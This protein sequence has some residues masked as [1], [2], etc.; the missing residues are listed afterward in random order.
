MLLLPFVAALLVARAMS[1]LAVPALLGVVG[2]FLVRE[3]LVVLARLA[4]RGQ[5]RPG[6]RESARKSLLVYGMV[7]SVCGLVLLWRL[8]R[9]PVLAMGLAAAVLTVIAVYLVVQNRQRSLLLQLVSAAGLN[10]SALPAWLCVRP[11]LEPQAWL[12][13]GLLFAHSAASVLAVHARLEAR[14][15]TASRRELKAMRRRATW[16]QV[17]LFVL[18]GGAVVWREWWIAGALALSAAVHFADLSRLGNAEFLRTRLQRVGVRELILS[19]VFAAIVALGLSIPG[20][21]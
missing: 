4:K 2:V 1:W 12:I 20:G 3:P 13:W 10:A 18:A 16:A 6:E 11:R 14:V 5:G 17:L 19:V 15:A 8:P 7:T 21:G 9:L